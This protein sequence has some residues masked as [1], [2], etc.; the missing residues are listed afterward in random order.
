MYIEKDVL[1]PINNKVTKEEEHHNRGLDIPSLILTSSCI[2]LVQIAVKLD[3]RPSRFALVRVAPPDYPV[4]RPPE[5]AWVY[6]RLVHAPSISVLRA[7]AAGL[8]AA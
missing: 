5:T 2:S 7:R 4:P 3:V 6:T 8:H 1:L